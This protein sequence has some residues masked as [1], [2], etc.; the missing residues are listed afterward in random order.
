MTPIEQLAK[1]FSRGNPAIESWL[2]MTNRILRVGDTVKTRGD[3]G[4]QTYK[5]VKIH[6]DH[7]CEVKKS[8]LGF[9]YG[10]ELHFN[11]NYFDRVKLPDG[12]LWIRQ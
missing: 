3:L 9:S 11:M 5:I 10:D 2:G 1:E 12:W 4:S 7:Y 6:N 8:I